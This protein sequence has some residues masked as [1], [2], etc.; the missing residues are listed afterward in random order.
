ML[1]PFEP[2]LFDPELF[3]PELLEPELPELFPAL[4]LGGADRDGLYDGDDLRDGLDR[5][6][7]ELFDLPLSP[8]FGLTCGDGCLG[9]GFE[10]FTLWFGSGFRC[11]LRT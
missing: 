6:T 4:D 7:L 2:E 5:R 10:R 8:D 3:D 1:F 11:G 9:A